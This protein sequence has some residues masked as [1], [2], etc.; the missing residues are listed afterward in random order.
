MSADRARA[1]W[2]SSAFNTGLVFRLADL[3]C[4][5]LPRSAVLSLSENLMQWYQGLRPDV[6][7][8]VADNIRKA[9][10][11]LAER[12]VEALAERTFVRYGQGVVDYLR[13]PHDPPRVASADGAARRL[14][15][16]PG[17]KVLVTAH[18]GNWEVGGIY[19]GQMIGRHWI[20]GFPERDPG[21]DAFRASR[22]EDSG[23]ATLSARQDLSTVF[24]LRSALE[25]GESVVVLVDRAAGSDRTPVRFRGRPSDFLKSP[26]L[27]AALSGVP[28]V[29]VA[30]VAEA[31]GEY[32]ALV[33]EPVAPTRETRPS[34]AMQ[35]PADFFSGVLERYPD[36][37]YNF[38]RYWQEGP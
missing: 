26:V 25:A 14:L 35:G 31:P 27:L 9:F 28:L 8:A 11:G 19:L 3:G 34:D 5:V 12:E 33:G 32:T 6:P 17:G 1:G 37:W 13:A 4:R 7:A 30:V 10:P 24:R 21:V 2:D 29:P 36:Q 15:A 38:F 20:V 22:R 23:H 18:M 16:I